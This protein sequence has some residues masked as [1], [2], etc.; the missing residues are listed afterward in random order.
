M[1]VAAWVVA[2]MLFSGSLTHKAYAHGTEKHENK[3]RPD[4]AMQ[5]VHSLMS[6]YEDCLSRISDALKIENK[7]Q[8]LQEVERLQVASQKLA[9]SNPYQQAR[10]VKMFKKHAQEFEREVAGLVASAAQDDISRVT[11]IFKQVEQ[12]CL[13]CHTT[14]N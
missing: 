11:V 12:K 10:Q 14:F 8:L 3:H 2:V 4:T 7:A 1:L 5:H 9:S 6:V 13:S